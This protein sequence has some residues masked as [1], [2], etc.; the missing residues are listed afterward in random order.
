LA[1]ADHLLDL[2]VEMLHRVPERQDR[3]H[4]LEE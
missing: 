2:P 1:T 3:L 4:A